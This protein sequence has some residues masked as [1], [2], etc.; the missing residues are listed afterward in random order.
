ML[1][2]SRGLW[3]SCIRRFLER[4][5]LSLRACNGIVRAV[6]SAPGF[7]NAF[8]V[9]VSVGKRSPS[10]FF[11]KP[12]HHR[13]M[14]QTYH[15]HHLNCNPTYSPFSSWAH[16]VNAS[17]SLHLYSLHTLY[18]SRLTERDD[19]LQRR[20]HGAEGF[21][22]WVQPRCR[23]RMQDRPCCLRACQSAVRGGHS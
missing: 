2:W 5:S 1:T 4:G 14:R 10:D 22:R 23:R 15:Y 12:H 3:C 18:P 17:V 8:F 6:D 16:L 21:V 19:D 13:L 9:H 7:I 11:H 20:A